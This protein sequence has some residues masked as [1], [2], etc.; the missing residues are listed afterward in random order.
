MGNLPSASEAYGSLS[1]PKSRKRWKRLYDR[2]VSI[3]AVAAGE[4]EAVAA[5]GRW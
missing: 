3:V 4:A 2:A 5:A 1:N